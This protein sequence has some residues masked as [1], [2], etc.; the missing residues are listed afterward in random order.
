MTSLSPTFQ[1]VNPLR[2]K[3]QVRK[4][5]DTCCEYSKFTAEGQ[6]G[7][8]TVEDRPDGRYINGLKNNPDAKKYELGSALA[9]GYTI[10][11]EDIKPEKI[12]VLFAV[13]VEGTDLDGKEYDTLVALTDDTQD[14]ITQY[15]TAG[16][17]IAA[18]QEL[19]AIAEKE[20]RQLTYTPV[21]IMSVD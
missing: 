18:A 2:S 11:K 13:W 5:S 9:T 7:V 19:R 10:C 1:P 21:T 20:G 14:I 6:Q 15:F 3:Y 17:A 16:D 8:T 12:G 4:V